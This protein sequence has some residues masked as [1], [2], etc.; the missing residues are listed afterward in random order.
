MPAKVIASGDGDAVTRAG[1]AP[2]V[3][4]A[5]APLATTKICVELP[6]AWYTIVVAALPDPMTAEEP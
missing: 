6:L 5:V 3:M 2:G 4:V 1:N